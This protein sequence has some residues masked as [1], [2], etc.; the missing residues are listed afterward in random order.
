MPQ[1]KYLGTRDDGA[2]VQLGHV[3]A[4]DDPAAVKYS[5]RPLMA[6]RARS[7][8]RRR[9]RGIG[10]ASGSTFLGGRRSGGSAQ[11]FRTSR[12]GLIDAISLDNSL[13]TAD[14]LARDPT[15]PI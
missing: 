2:V 9:Q 7:I 14:S 13:E 11:H 6:G 10:F 8:L 12:S 3:P 15:F 5:G 4:R 1:P